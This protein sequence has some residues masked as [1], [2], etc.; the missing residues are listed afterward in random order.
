MKLLS[1]VL[2]AHNEED[3]IAPLVQGLSELRSEIGGSWGLECIFV[4][5]GSTDR[6]RSMIL[7]ARRRLPELKIRLIALDKRWGLTAA[8]DAGFR[9]SRGS[10]VATMDTDLQNDPRD[11]PE[12]L[13]HIE[14]ADVVAGVRVSRKDPFVKK[15]SSKIANAIRNFATN[16]DIVDTGCSLKV[17]RKE[18]INRVK[19]FSGLHRFLPTIL[20]MEGARVLQVPVSHRC[21]LHGSSKYHLTNRLVGPLVDLLAVRWMQ[22]R[23]LSYHWEEI[24]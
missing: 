18:Y 10:V 5:D 12:L 21:R 4:D 3:N 17:F 16:E 2:P 14:E 6:T 8:L 22:K 7:E 24:E 19:L 20:K 13:S 9:V 23:H 1:I 11:L 15:L